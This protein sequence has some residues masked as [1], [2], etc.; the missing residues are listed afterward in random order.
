M[1][2][3]QPEALE[4]EIERLNK[5][6]SAFIFQVDTLKE[7]NK[8]LV[9][10]ILTIQHEKPMEG[11]D[12]PSIKAGYSH[13]EKD[14]SPLHG[15]SSLAENDKGRNI[16]NPS[17]AEKSIGIS[18]NTSSLAENSKGIPHVIS[19]LIEKYKGI[20]INTPSLV[21]N[22]KAISSITSSHAE[23]D[24]E[25]IK[26]EYVLPQTIAGTSINVSRLQSKLRGSVMKIS[27]SAT[28]NATAKLL[29]H[30]YN[31]GNGSYS[32]MKNVIGYSEGGLG[33]LMII[34]R[35]KGLVT[36]NGYQKWAPS[37]YALQL[38]KEA[39]LSS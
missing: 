7:D 38:M 31:K 16:D 33:K 14:N 15:T 35:K 5:I 34:L 2:T 10:Y 29:I 32:S 36:S 22:D 23:K 13:A 26:Q 20:S 39:Q 12:N 11:S 8:D 25:K 21:E 17:L 24:N 30:L 3:L 9:N 37:A 6:I 19:S 27:R 28:R 1:T 18:E 4:K